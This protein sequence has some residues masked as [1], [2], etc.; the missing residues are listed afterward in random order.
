MGL[1]SDDDGPLTDCFP[2]A[3]DP[4]PPL[5]TDPYFN[6]PLAITAFDNN[7]GG[8]YTGNKVPVEDDYGSG[9]RCGHWRESVLNDELMT[10]FTEAPSTPM[11]LSEVTVKALADMGYTVAASGWDTWTCPGCAPLPLG[12][13]VPDSNAGLRL[14]NDMWLG[15]IYSVDQ[16]GRLTLARPDLRR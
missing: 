13:R 14:L 4:P 5:T 16:N 3:D 8:T 12:E 15:P 11:P 10:G 2:V 7:G 6:G 1:L 9:T